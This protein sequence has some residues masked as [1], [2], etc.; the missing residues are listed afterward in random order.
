MNYPCVFSNVIK[1]GD[2]YDLLGFYTISIKPLNL[3]DELKD[4]ALIAWKSAAGGTSVRSAKWDG[5]MLTAQT[6]E[7]GSYY[8]VIDTT[9]P[10]IT[11][12]N[13][14]K[15]KNMHA[16]K[17]ISMSIRDNLSGISEYKGYIDG[18]W[19]LMELDG[20]TGILRMALPASLSAGEHIFKLTVTDDRNNK[21]EY[22][23][24]FNY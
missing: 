9:P 2:S 4:K 20:K 16:L 11:A 7:F 12:I 5:D 21:S 8:I 19:Q 3:P 15:G 14:I 23:V 10:K 6:R 13:I 18:K 22:S 1:I 24:T 17:T